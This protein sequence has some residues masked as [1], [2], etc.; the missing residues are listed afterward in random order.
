MNPVQY[1]QSAP[2]SADMLSQLL[3]QIPALQQ[4]MQMATEASRNKW[5]ARYEKEM[6]QQTTPHKPH[7]LRAPA[8][9]FKALNTLSAQTSPSRSRRSL[10]ASDRSASSRQMDVDFNFAQPAEIQQE[11]WSKDNQGVWDHEIKEKVQ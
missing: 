8:M 10:T 11:N 1:E 9:Q 4:Q 6:K 2:T 7:Q 5:G 3:S